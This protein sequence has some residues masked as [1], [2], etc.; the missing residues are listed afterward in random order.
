MQ[1]QSR[2]M[3]D[4][5]ADVKTDTDKA[6]TIT[7]EGREDDKESE[8]N[9]NEKEMVG[10]VES[11]SK[12]EEETKATQNKAEIESTKTVKCLPETENTNDKDKDEKEI[13][14][15]SGTAGHHKELEGTAVNSDKDQQPASSEVKSIENVACT[16]ENTGDDSVGNVVPDVE[17]VSLESNKDKEEISEPQQISQSMNT[18]NQKETSSQR[19]TSDS[20]TPSSNSKDGNSEEKSS[21]EASTSST[22]KHAEHV[23]YTEDGCAIY[24]DP[25]T[26]YQYKW[27]TKTNNWTPLEAQNTTSGSNTNPYENEHYKWCTETQKWIPKQQAQAQVTET[28]HYKWD[29]VKQQ[30]IPKKTTTAATEQLHPTAIVYDI[31]EDGQRIYTDK[32]GT[33]FFW[34]E[35]KNAWFPKIDDDFMARYQMSYGFIDN[36]S[37]SEKEKQ[38]LEEKAA[39]LKQKELQQMT[40]EAVRSSEES[41][42]GAAAGAVAAKRKAPPEPPSRLTLSSL[43]RPSFCYFFVFFFTSFV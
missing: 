41:V 32:D 28:E 6:E 22:D 1:F 3:S 24:T 4:C 42:K 14:L 31:D 13:S 43:K 34:D 16:D 5:L 33:V 39:E 10:N 35:E 15:A 27:C 17:T 9:T 23:T 40:E 11:E 20:S 21:S 29:A 30:W 38:Q 19:L 8:E 18:N 25:A 7:I 2:N 37:A 12:I 36:T 26:K